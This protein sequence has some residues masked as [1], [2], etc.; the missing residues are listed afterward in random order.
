MHFLGTAQNGAEV[1]VDL[2]RSEAGHNIARRPQLLG[3]VKEIL[4]NMR[5]SGSE[6]RIERDMGR[7]LGYDFV[8]H[9]VDD[10]TIFYAQILHDSVYTRFVKNGKPALTQYASF[11]LRSREG[12]DGYDLQEVRIGRLTPPRPGSVDETPESRTYWME[13]ALIHDTQILQPRTTTKTCPY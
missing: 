1:Y 7:T 12:M 6:I 4:A 2:I 8:I 13:H 5:L 9:T 11:V 3:I 10:N